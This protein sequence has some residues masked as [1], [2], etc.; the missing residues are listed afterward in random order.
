[1]TKQRSLFFKY[2][3]I[4]TA[5][6]LISFIC[7][8]AVLLLISSNFFNR[9]MEER[10]EHSVNNISM[11]LSSNMKNAPDDW[12]LGS[13]KA[14]D[15]YANN[16]S[17]D[18]MIFDA[19]GKV[20][21]S[22][23]QYNIAETFKKNA[24][25]A[26]IL[27]QYG[28]A[29]TSVYTDL[30]GILDGKIMTVGEKFTGNGPKY[31]IVAL[32]AAQREN[33]Y[34]VA[35][36][37]IFAISCIIVLI[38]SMVIIYF[39]SIKMTDPIKEMAE[40]AKKIGRGNF[41]IHLPEYS[42]REYNDLA[43]AFNEMAVSIKNYDIVRNSFIANVSHE[44]RTPMT[45]I[46]GFVDGLLDETIPKEEQRHYLEIISSEVHR[47]TRL[48]RSMLNLAKI[49]AGELKP[50]FT[51]FSVLDPIV[52]TLMTFEKRLEEKNIEVL[53]LDTD[54]RYYLWADVDLVH[55]VIYNLLENAIKFVDV[56]GYI[57]FHFQE[58]GAYTIIY[59]KNSGEGLSQEE[60][61]LVFDRFYKTDKSRS[62]DVNGVGLGL[63]IVRSII[64]LHGGKIQVRSIEKEYTE[65]I[66][67]LPNKDI[68]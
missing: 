19:G 35:I 1:M 46:G 16:V 42:E 41:D 55:Q 2:F 65:F 49:E 47:L 60:L 57:R 24:L 56:G 58:V 28:D 62:M 11:T 66:F 33:G 25:S 32:P 67:S 7:L 64:K 12:R 50:N 44:L 53:G 22:A 27:E 38:I 10:L 30:G 45:S 20:V 52:D 8:G 37:N 63:N 48:V 54:K 36:M 43:A 5:V 26:D 15:E 21:M 14:L 4:C 51:R 34:T 68:T 17:A 9:Q 40:A 61:S 59:I 29:P 23:A 6:I 3:S 39:T 18:I 13:Q 31:Y